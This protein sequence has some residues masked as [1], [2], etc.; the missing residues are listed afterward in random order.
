MS[1]RSLRTKIR[2]TPVWG[3]SPV[4]YW[5]SGCPFGCTIVNDSFTGL[6]A[7]TGPEGVKPEM[8]LTPAALTGGS[9]TCDDPDPQPR[10]QAVASNDSA[11]TPPVSALLRL[12]PGRGGSCAAGS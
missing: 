5:V 12:A 1:A 6:P 3:P 4:A 11:S 8:W 10:L 7:G 2:C 9:V